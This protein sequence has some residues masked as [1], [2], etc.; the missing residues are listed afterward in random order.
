M[1]KIKNQNIYVVMYHYVKK[2]SE[3]QYKK[4]KFLKLKR[5]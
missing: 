1:I 4:L 3:N 5:V 2:V